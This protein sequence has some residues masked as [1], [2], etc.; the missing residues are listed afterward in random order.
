MRSL[1][2]SHLHWNQPRPSKAAFVG[3]KHTC[4]TRNRRSR[5]L[6]Q[7]HDSRIR[8]AHPWAGHVHRHGRTRCEGR[9]RILPMCAMCS[10]PDK[11]NVAVFTGRGSIVLRLTGLAL[12]NDLKGEVHG[13]VVLLK[14]KKS[15]RN[16]QLTEGDT[17]SPEVQV[18][19]LTRRITELTEHFKDH[20]HDHHS[21]RGLPPSSV[22]V[23]E[24]SSTCSASRSSVTARSSSAWVC[25]AET[26]ALTLSAAQTN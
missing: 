15:S 5:R 8:L 2:R 16:M 12:R 6:R 23:V 1:V 10:T 20:K 21:R 18:A 26:S 13:F 24:C 19:L 4:S 3:S 22:S 9:T 14:S 25:V 17:G 11:L 7:A